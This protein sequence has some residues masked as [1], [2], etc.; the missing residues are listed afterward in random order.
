MGYK[1]FYIYVDMIF[2]DLICLCPEIPVYKL[3]L[4]LMIVGAVIPTVGYKWDF[5][6]HRPIVLGFVVWDFILHLQSGSFSQR[7]KVVSP[8]L[9]FLKWLI[10]Y[11]IWILVF[12]QCL[13]CT[14]SSKGKTR[15]YVS[16]IG[17]GNAIRLLI[18]RV[19][20]VLLAMVF[21]CLFWQL[22][23][24]GV[25]LGGV[26][27]WY[28]FMLIVTILF[29]FFSWIILV[30]IMSAGL[31]CLHLMSCGHTHTFWLLELDLLLDILWLDFF[32]QP[33]SIK[34]VCAHD[35][36]IWLDDKS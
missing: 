33:F 22:F 7:E 5:F 18:V 3:V 28:I 8:L 20:L 19:V 14:S 23:P 17:N 29:S 30:L 34:N 9:L 26:L 35:T 27:I 6:L 24:F 21:I 2:F 31:S 10:A 13:Q 1:W 36:Q 25:L 16:G 12:L 32:R 15:K 4:F 11:E